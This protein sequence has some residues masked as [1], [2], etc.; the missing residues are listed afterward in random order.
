MP[1][2]S[3][4][5]RRVDVW[6]DIVR[7][8]LLSE[9]DVLMFLYRHG[10]SLASAENIALLLGYSKSVVGKA[11][12]ALG[13]LGLVERSRAYQGARFYRFTLP[14]EPTCQ[15]VLEELLKLSEKRSGRL[16]IARRLSLRMPTVQLPARAG[17]RLA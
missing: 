13:G 12:D 8:S 15:Q 11:L 17:W 10:T 16:V 3:Q 2:A 14:R 6:L 9:W 1:E 7:I 5:E 4:L